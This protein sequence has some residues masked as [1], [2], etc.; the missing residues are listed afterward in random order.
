MVRQ[1]K[2][3]RGIAERSIC[4]LR[5]SE[6]CRLAL[7]RH[8]IRRIGDVLQL[9][10]QTLLT[11]AGLDQERLAELHRALAEALEETPPAERHADRSDADP[12]DG[13]SQ[14]LKEWEVPR[15]LLGDLE[16]SVD[17]L[18]LSVRA[19][20]ALRQAGIRSIRQ[21]LRY[22]KAG[23][24]RGGNFGR[25]SLAE[26]ER[27][28]FDYL[29]G[30]WQPASPDA[31]SGCALSSKLAAGGTKAF[32]AWLLSKLK[33]REASV[34]AD[35]YG[36]WDGARETL[37]D[38]GGKYG[39]TR[40]RVRQIEAK[41]LGRLR[42]VYGVAAKRHF[43]AKLEGPLA[44]LFRANLGLLSQEEIVGGFADDCTDEEACLAVTLLSD[45][46]PEQNPFTGCLIELEQDVYCG[47]RRV[48]AA[49]KAVLEAARRTLREGRRPLAERA[50]CDLIV[51]QTGGQLPET[52]KMLSRIL[53]VSPSIIRL[54]DSSIAFSH[55][56]SFRR[57][58]AASLAE[59]ALVVLGRPAHFSEI[60]DRIAAL[61][62]ELGAVSQGSVHNALVA[63]HERFVWVRSGTYGL[64]VWGL[65]RPPYIK[66]KLVQLLSD[67]RY[68]LPY[69][70]LEKKVLEVCNCRPTSVRMTLDLNPKVF[71]RFGNHQ[72]GLREHYEPR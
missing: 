59:A 42:Q 70:H 16:A 63:R 67:S 14:P 4:D 35:R 6:F 50:L 3:L 33:D 29:G 54:S 52:G 45:T 38:I 19:T 13:A 11:V 64:R 34:I 7:I 48:A 18:D 46:F 9:S 53:D 61:Y 2:T 58:T 36:L 1:V 51:G 62:P 27:K 25:T 5:I 60:A 21:L 72:Y 40:E 20:N 56:L 43:S 22:P 47:D 49:Y 41:A 30:R 37:E 69:W 65:Q 23:L 32:V 15:F 31:A 17:L 8:G 71:K 55:W 57:R 66:D 12:S 68:P 26:V 10:G 24:L 39:V 28:V 44:A